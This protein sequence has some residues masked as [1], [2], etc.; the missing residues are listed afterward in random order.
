MRDRNFQELLFKVEDKLKEKLGVNYC[1]L[2]SIADEIVSLYLHKHCKTNECEYIQ[3]LRQYLLSVDFL[4]WLG[5]N[6]T[7]FKK[8]FNF[9]K[10]LKK[11]EKE[12]YKVKKNIYHQWIGEKNQKEIER[13]KKIKDLDFLDET[14]LNLLKNYPIFN[15]KEKNEFKKELGLC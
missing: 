4:E 14:Y 1:G 10:A 15:P 8:Q 6:Y 13:L 9:K 2:F 3:C 11:N 7:Q 12:I 5:H